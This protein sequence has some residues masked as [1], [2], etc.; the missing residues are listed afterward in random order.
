MAR[1]VQ[2]A[3]VSGGLLDP[4]P[5]AKLSSPWMWSSSAPGVH[6]PEQ[7]RAPH[8][9]SEVP[10]GA[11]DSHG[12]RT[13]SSAGPGSPG[14]QQQSEIYSAEQPENNPEECLFSFLCVRE[15]KPDCLW[16]GNAGSPTRGSSA[17]R[18]A[19]AGHSQPRVR[20]A[21]PWCARPRSGDLWSD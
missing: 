17:E 9:I 3:E 19:A 8:G 16:P 12:M 1:A 4:D 13:G 21:P 15:I 5:G 10:P 2:A 14:R 6:G 11:G 18:A 20:A 7:P